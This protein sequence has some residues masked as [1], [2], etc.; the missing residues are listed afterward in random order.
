MIAFLLPERAA[1]RALQ[2][3]GYGYEEK[4]GA[5]LTPMR[6]ELDLLNHAAV[7]AW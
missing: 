7:E 3:K 4:G 1:W 6:Q 5:L 2:E